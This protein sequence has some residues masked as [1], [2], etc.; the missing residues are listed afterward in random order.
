MLYTDATRRAMKVAY[1]AHH[2]QLDKGGVP[3]VF[4][5]IHLAEQMD[6]EDE[7]C[8]ALLHDVIED[9]S[10]TADELYAMGFSDSVMAILALLTHDKSVPYLDYVCA[11]KNSKYA[12]AI[13]IKLA[14]L[15][16]N[17]D[18]S[19]ASGDNNPERMA[20]YKEAIRILTE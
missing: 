16:H 17:S 15:H 1:D 11:I 6:T 9:T 19:R 18:P 20:K 8:A 13:K 4:H 5:P 3:Y 14:D 12:A 10:V 2:G 7:I